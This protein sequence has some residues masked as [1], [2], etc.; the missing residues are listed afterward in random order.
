MECA[1]K[2]QTSKLSLVWNDEFDDTGRPKMEHWMFDLGGH[3]WG[4]NELQFYTDHKENAFV[5]NGK[6]FIIAIQQPFGKNAFTSARLVSK[7]RFDFTY[8]RVEVRAKI[9]YGIGTWPAI[10]MLPSEQ[11]YGNAYWPDNGEIDIMEHVGFDP[12]VV[13]GNIH[14]KAFNHSIGTNKGNRIVVENAGNE[15]HTYACNWSKDEISIE[16]DGNVFFRFE[17]KKEYTWEEWPFDQPFHIILNI[18]V[19]GN[20]GGQKGVDNT[21]FPSTM[22]IDYVRVFEA[23]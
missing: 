7:N 12:N 1:C 19:G 16:V 11:S 22:E 21:A 20:W 8:G 4:N 2:A 17:K 23:Q 18:A 10:W 6:L 3:G 5:E 13:H 9:P 14:T 15:F